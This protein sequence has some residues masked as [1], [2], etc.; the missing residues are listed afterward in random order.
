[1][2]TL[3]VLIIVILSATLHE[4]MHGWVA[5]NLGDPTAKLSGRLTLNPIAHLDLFGSLILPL[6][7]TVV[8]GPIFA[9]AKPVPINPAYFKNYKKD[10]LIT[11]L[12]GP[13]TNLFIAL[14][15]LSTLKIMLLSGATTSNVL[16]QIIFLV[17]LVNIFLAV[18]NV[19]P[20]PPL[21]GSKVLYYVLGDRPGLLQ[22]LERY[23]FV[24][25][26]VVLIF[27]GGII[28]TV[29]NGALDIIFRAFG[30]SDALVALMGSL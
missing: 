21:D 9:Y 16:T 27:F 7:L 19:L 14:I 17:V 8:G 1:M 20:I 6:M 18:F 13:L 12:A 25:F 10:M 5:F 24:L 2:A 11:A 3:L 22:T 23:G 29:L 26:F 4:F 15:F 30:M 28:G